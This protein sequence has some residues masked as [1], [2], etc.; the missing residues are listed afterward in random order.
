MK[1]SGLGKL[2][3]LLYDDRADIYRTDKGEN[4]DESVDIFYQPDPLYTD[5]KCRISMSSD[6]TGTDSEVDEHP[7]RFNP[8]LFFGPDV[9]I[10]AGDYVVVR[11]LD[12]TGAVKQ[13]YEG[14]VSKPSWYT[15]HQ[16]VF[17]RVDEEA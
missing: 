9:D 17:L 15:S 10:K 4:Q 14:V 8:K 7:V 12:D 3:A 11:R 2:F 5:V 6:D 13:T 16:E 1:L